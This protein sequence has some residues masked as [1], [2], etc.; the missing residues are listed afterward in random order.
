MKVLYSNSKSPAAS[1]RTTRHIPQAPD[2]V[3]DAPE[4]VNDYYLSLLDW[5]VDNFLAVALGSN[6]Y[7]WNAASGSIRQL[8]DLPDPEDHVC[9][10]KW[11]KE[12]NILAVGN[13]T[14]DIALWDVESMRKLRIMNGHTDRV[15][16]LS[17]NP[18]S[19]YILSSGS[20]SGDIHHQ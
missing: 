6:I 18:A 12:G 20:R 9:S 15:G 1:K 14:G 16:S 17:W 19:P 11:A 2:R 13:T 5:S 8:L 7:L 3:L 10:V 4:L